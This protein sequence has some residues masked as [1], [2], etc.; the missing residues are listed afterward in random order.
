MLF[1]KKKKKEWKKER[2]EKKKKEKKKNPPHNLWK[3]QP[4]EMTSRK[5]FAKRETGPF[6][7]QFFC[8]QLPFNPTIVQ[9]GLIFIQCSIHSAY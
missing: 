3:T 4:I 6:V 2:K 1:K 7:T 9:K 5:S 8:W